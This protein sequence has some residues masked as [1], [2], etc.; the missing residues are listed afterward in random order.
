MQSTRLLLWSLVLVSAARADE[1]PTRHSRLEQLMKSV[2]FP[3]AVEGQPFDFTL[4]LANGKKLDSKSLRGR[5]V[6]LD[7]W[8][9][10]CG[11][12]VQEIPSVKA[13]YD[14]YHSRGLEIVGVSFDMKTET[15]TDFVKKKK[16]PWPQYVASKPNLEAA[17][18][19][20]IGISGI[21][22]F[23]LIGP[24]GR[25]VTKEARG[26]FEELIVPLLSP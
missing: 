8:A 22:T 12:C 11:P 6:L 10:W 9:T 24:D 19:R 7:F 13:L 25:L 23:F 3:E 18:M 21:P 26:R 17:I 4:D 1:I 2:P 14:K 5:V 16:I 20:R 15:A